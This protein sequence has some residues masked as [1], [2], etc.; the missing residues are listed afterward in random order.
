MKPVF[1]SIKK[2]LKW[3]QQQLVQNGKILSSTGNG[4]PKMC[5]NTVENQLLD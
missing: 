4:V 3:L 2:T 1:R 5:H